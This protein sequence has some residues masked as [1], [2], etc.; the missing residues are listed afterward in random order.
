[1]SYIDEERLPERA[2][3][4]LEFW[5]GAIDPEDGSWPE[6]QTE[7]WFQG[8]A[9]ADRVI[10]ERFGE[11]I[12]R[13]ARGEYSSWEETPR[14]QLALILLFDQFTRNVWRGRPEAFQYD[15]RARAI[16]HRLIEL[17]GHT[18][19]WPIER[20]FVYMPLEHTEALEPQR[21]CVRLMEQLEQEVPEAMRETFAYFTEFARR[22]LEIIE[23]FGRFPH[24]NATLGR[25][26]TPGEVAYLDDGGE[27][28]GQGGGDEEQ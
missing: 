19:L 3:E 25:V 6:E 14:G 12:E 16:S 28:F 11:D 9:R 13:A 1:M 26:S 2:A 4:V 17:G 5:F 15:D 24:R 22:H 18:E 20:L 10:T 23:R 8:G 27:T 21:L 7:L